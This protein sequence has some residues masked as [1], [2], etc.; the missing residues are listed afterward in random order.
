ML[1]GVKIETPTW[2]D[3]LQVD[4]EYLDRNGVCSSE[5]R[6]VVTKLI[7]AWISLLADSPLNTCTSNKPLRV[8]QAFLDWLLSQPIRESVVFLSKLA[9]E[10]VSQPTLYG[11]GSITGTDFLPA[12][13]DTPVFFEYVRWR[14]TGD[15]SILRY[16]LT[17]LTFGK[18]VEYKDP[19]LTQNALR[20]WEE[21][22]DKL[23]TFNMPDDLA[24]D[25]SSII[26]II[27]DDLDNDFPLMGKHGP[28]AVA[29]PERGS[30]AKT[31][32]LSSTPI[33]ERAFDRNINVRHKLFDVIPTFRRV[34]A[35]TINVRM[36][37]L[38]F[39]PKN[40]KTERSICME[41]ANI[42]YAQQAFRWAYEK[43]IHSG[44]A[45]RWIKLH[46]QSRNQKL[47]DLGSYTGEVDTI[48]LAAASDSVSL[49]LV[50]RIFPRRILYW[51]LATRS[52]HVLK[53]DG[54][55]VAVRKF[56]PMG[57]ALCF[58]TQSLIY[59]SVVLRSYIIHKHGSVPTDRDL[60][61]KYLNELPTGDT[62]YDGLYP[63]AV[64]GD[65]IILDSKMS[66][67]LIS[68]LRS[69]C[70]TVNDDK[71]F[72][73]SQAYRESCGKHYYVGHDVTPLSFKIKHFERQHSAES[74][75]SLISLANRAGDYRY[76]NLQRFLIQSCL[77][78]NLFVERGY[79]VVH[80]SDGGITRRKNPVA[81]SANR[82][83]SNALYSH[84]PRNDHLQ[85][86]E[87]SALQRAEV[88][89]LTVE[90]KKRRYTDSEEYEHYRYQQYWRAWR[91]RQ[92]VSHDAVF[93][94]SPYV[95]KIPHYDSFGAVLRR[96]WAPLQQLEA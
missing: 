78:D 88:H 32:S 68:T 12:L 93:G 61:Q 55:I 69:L 58:P 26:D 44:L 41:P 50:R 9:D 59:L 25:L 62:P 1:T 84:H 64:Y 30:I 40:V 38:M 79:T 48:D 71:S 89:L 2:V 87:N 95:E 81:F 82:N 13:K 74:L 56:A 70:F 7:L 51:L 52:T 67:S 36:A 22:E 49:E 63:C 6:F 91:L 16:L 18:R 29:G 33:L 15:A 4:P 20:K 24:R 37:R 54:A 5:N 75:A 53:P 46:D 92:Q 80:Q 47:A 73:A 96:R 43:A 8:Y 28:G 35:S 14:K 45:G 60:L 86:R 94:D 19:G 57:S 65:D 42:M 10:L 77:Y 90:T 72:M 27:V 17:F 66:Q 21:V 83:F 85:S 11:S 76:L 31:L 23:S 34:C 39:V 3:F